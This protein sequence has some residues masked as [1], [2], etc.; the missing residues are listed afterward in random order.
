MRT[1]WISLKLLLFLTGV[2][3]LLYPL[4][5]TSVAQVF[6]TQKAN[7]SLIMKDGRKV[8]SVYIGQLFDSSAYFMSRP[9]SVGYNPL[10][11]GGSNLGPTSRRLEKLVEKRRA[12]FIAFNQLDSMTEVP[13]D[14][15]FASAS[16]VDPHI[17]PEA[18]FLQ[19]DRI[20]T[21]RKYNKMQRYK[22]EK[23]IESQ[24]ENPQYLCLGEKRVNVL[25]LNL[26]T[27]KIK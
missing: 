6:F 14:M 19:L 16:G 5:V 18:A 26:E 7:G 8:G 2:T 24:I 4:F 21:V 20:A 11:S 13:S 17:T 15:V 27:Y 10:P 3:G 9:S 1:L 23:L 25:L 12:H 22:L